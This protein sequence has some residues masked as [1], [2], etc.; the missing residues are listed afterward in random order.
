MRFFANLKV[1]AKL[2]LLLGVMLAGFAVI[3][4][5]Y[6][7]I[8]KAEEKTAETT[9]ALSRFHLEIEKIVQRLGEA[10]MYQ[11][12]F[13]LNRQ[14]DDLEEFESSVADTRENL[15]GLDEQTNDAELKELISYVQESLD[16]YHS[17][18]YQL[19]ET[20]ISVGLNQESGLLGDM[21]TV[22]DEL[23][24]S[25]V[26]LKDRTSFGRQALLNEKLMISL[27]TIQKREAAYLQKEEFE[28]V[29]P[30]VAELPLLLNW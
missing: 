1:A 25:L 11:R 30:M 10:V 26:T 23:E 27:L 17:A 9:Q 2:A 13:L 3:G 15:S 12:D 19:A 5:T 18:V 6:M 21:R 28:L 20:R 16:S 4:A 14:L 7:N 22:S 24:T 29:A 8:L